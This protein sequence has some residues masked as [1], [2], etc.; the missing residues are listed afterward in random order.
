MPPQEAGKPQPARIPLNYFTQ[1]DPLRRWKVILTIAAALAAAAWWLSGF[2]QSDGGRLRYS[3]GPVAAVHAMWDEDCGR[4]HT[5]FHPIRSDAWSAVFLDSAANDPKCMTCHSG[6]KH[7]ET[8]ADTPA[9]A[10]CHHEHQGRD[11]SLIRSPDSACVRCHENLGAHVL[12]DMK[13]S[14]FENKVTRF[15]SQHHPEIRAVTGEDPGKLKF[16]HKLHMT[17][18]MRLDPEG[19]PFRYRDIAD[20]EA[21]K[22]YWLATLQ[23]DERTSATAVEPEAPVRLDCSSCHRL[24]AG[25]FG[26]G[27]EQL[28][29]LPGAALLPPRAAG[30]YMQ[31]ITYEVQCKACHPLTFD[32]TAPGTPDAKYVAAPHRLQPEALHDFLEGYY[33]GQYF[34][35]NRTLFERG[36]PAR[37]IPGKAVDPTVETARQRISEQVKTAEKMLYVGKKTCGE[38]HYYED[39]EDGLIPRKIVAPEVPTIWLLHAKFSHTAH[40]AMKCGDCHAKAYPDPDG[41]TSARDVLIPG[42]ATCVQC[43]APST[44]SGGG[45]RFD[46]VECHRYHHGDTPLLG[47]G[48]EKRNPRTP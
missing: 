38:C 1:G 13:G 23:P 48:T 4:C 39:G 42:I 19:K 36:W 3:R 25:D 2:L 27:G 41:S 14:G 33:T 34:R 31:P 6:P 5:S 46:C 32:C 17:P 8:Q 18:G 44:S 22:R 16:N 29:L 9:C 15:D 35:G 12:G 37:L 20:M 47:I 11:A 40:R 45:A 24:D 30:A 7:H 26:V 43:H 10:V 21:Q 28:A